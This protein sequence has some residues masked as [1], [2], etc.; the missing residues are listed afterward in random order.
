MKKQT[1]EPANKSVHFRW[2]TST[3][4]ANKFIINGCRATMNE[5]GTYQIVSAN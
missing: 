3:P 5:F 4:Y 1:S 2:D